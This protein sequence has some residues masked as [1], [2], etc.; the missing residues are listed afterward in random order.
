[1][2]RQACGSLLRL[3]AREVASEGAIG[4]K[5]VLRSLS[6]VSTASQAT[7]LLTGV[8]ALLRPSFAASGILAQHSARSYSTDASWNTILYPESELEIGSPAPDFAA[9]GKNGHSLSKSSLA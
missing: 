7:K 6:T 4:S 5:Q 3:L 8:E 1:M 9:P 2:R